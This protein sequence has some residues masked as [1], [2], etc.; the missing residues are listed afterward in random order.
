MVA[1]D[2][3][4]L[5]QG[6]T[7]L[8]AD[9]GAVTVVGEAADADDLLTVVRASSPDAV[10]T[11][12][13]MPPG[14]TGGLTAVH[15]VRALGPGVVALSQHADPTWAAELF[16]D[17]SDGLAYLLKDRIA[18]VGQLVDALRTVATGGSVVDPRIV[19]LLVAHRRDTLSALSP[20]ELD[21]LH[22]MASGR[23]NQAIAHHLH[24]SA[25]T[26]EKHVN[27]I[28]TKLHLPPDDAH[29][30]RRVTAVLTF[31]RHRPG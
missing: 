16:R 25:S 6:I 15:A 30:H 11:D 8:L 22:A 31:L 26:V 19:E 21:V 29:R 7:R 1:D 3:F 28:F 20:R 13:R 14:E 18:D 12:L 9:T 27:A 10:L 23:T 17:G 2:H 24:L 4:L 5:R